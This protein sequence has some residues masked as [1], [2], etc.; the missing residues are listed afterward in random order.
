[1]AAKKTSRSA[2]KKAAKSRRPAKAGKASTRKSPQPKKAGKKAAKKKAAKKP[3]ATRIAS[4]TAEGDGPTEARV[5]S[6]QRLIDVMVD[7]GAVEVELREGES[8]I[9]VRLKED[10]PTGWAP[11]AVAAM[12]APSGTAYAASSHPAA[13]AP[14]APEAPEGEVFLSPMVGTFYRASS[15]DAEPFA[16]VGDRAGED[17]TICIIEAM[18]VMNEIKAERSF[19]V[20]EVLAENGE[21][22]EFG[23]PLFRIR[24]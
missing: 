4:V 3:R 23:Q 18:K 6:V 5:A 9:R 22:V 12:P 14:A 19:E 21:P 15:P 2:A 10:P 13:A 8:R 24:D 20:L 16:K 17:T 1:M 11:A 7:R